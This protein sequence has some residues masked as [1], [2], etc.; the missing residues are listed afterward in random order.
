MVVTQGIVPSPSARTSHK[1]H[2]GPSFLL[3]DVPADNSSKRR[4]LSH[5]TSPPSRFWDGLSA[6]PLTTRAL[7]EFDR[8][9]A[10]QKP[11][12][13]R[14]V[15]DRKAVAERNPFLRQPSPRFEKGLKKF[16]SHGG[17]DLRDLRGVSRCLLPFTS[18]SGADSQQCRPSPVAG[19]K[20]SSSTLSSLGRRKR[21]SQSPVKSNTTPNTT[22]TR[23]TSAYDRAFQQH[24][25]DHDILPDKY[26]FPN[27][28]TPQRLDSVEEIRHALSQPRP[29]LSP[30]QFSDERF[31]DFQ[32]ADAHAFKESQVVADVIPI[33]E[34]D[35]GDR[36]CVARQVP[37]SNLDPLTD[38][39]LVAACP[40]LYYG[41]R[42]EQLDQRVRKQLRGRIV[43]STQEDLPVA[44]NFFVEVKGPDGSAAVAKRQIAYDTAL[45]ERGLVDL[46]S[47]G[48][49]N[50]AYNAQTHT[51]GCTYQDGQLKIFATHMI[52]PSKPGAQPGFVMTQ[53]K[54][55]ALT[56]DADGFR[57]GAA[58]YRNAR[59]WAK[60]KRDQAI[61]QANEKA[62]DLDFPGLPQGVY[63]GRSFMS[64][65]SVAGT[66]E[67]TSQ[68]T[69]TNLESS[70]PSLYD[71]DTSADEL[72]L[73]SAPP[74]KRKK[75]IGK[76]H[77]VRSNRS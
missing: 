12:R 42:P 26:A 28:Q 19:D 73:D 30:S 32:R 22:A 10:V 68:A 43:P 9:N 49:R 5:P 59:D 11:R 29:S 37:F 44:P 55:S 38:G 6:I 54:A 45:G 75:G 56:D 70:T 13:S 7:N 34:G 62:E 65:V 3:S 25:I 4:K 69:I 64:E 40:D 16:A 24:F 31:E 50:P 20:M 58:T 48:G 27:G 41:A 21:G 63:Q 71:S 67:Q 23:S 33:L 53:V 72:S 52:A 66:V 74:D 36:K 39:T 77:A 47:V 46:G 60:Q 8:R 61:A 1:R 57:R 35:I 15:R 17:P 51:L 14:R 2:H 18:N 76:N